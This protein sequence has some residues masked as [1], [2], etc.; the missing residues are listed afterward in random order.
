LLH[1]QPQGMNI[2]RV[3][4]PVWHTRNPTS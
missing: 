2:M 3:G 1:E 4:T